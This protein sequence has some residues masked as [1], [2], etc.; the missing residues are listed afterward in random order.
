M[1]RRHT[2]APNTPPGHIVRVVN[3][4][5][6]K[7]VLVVRVLG[8]ESIQQGPAVNPLFCTAVGSRDDPEDEKHIIDN[9]SQAHCL[10]R[11]SCIPHNIELFCVLGRQTVQHH[12][13]IVNLCSAEEELQVKLHF[14]HN[15]ATSL[16]VFHWCYRFPRFGFWP[17]RP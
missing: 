10:L 17:P 5:I 7:Y 13:T 15:Q 8:Q 1:C 9:R 3:D 12:D 4:V 16:C 11:L 6:C 2:H 14:R